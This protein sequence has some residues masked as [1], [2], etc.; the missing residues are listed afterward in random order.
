MSIRRSS[1]FCVAHLQVYE[2]VADNRGWPNIGGLLYYTK[3]FYIPTA[4]IAHSVVHCEKLL[5][6]SYTQCTTAETLPSSEFVLRTRVGVVLCQ[7]ICYTDDFRT[8]SMNCTSEY[9]CL[10]HSTVRNCASSVRRERN[11]SITMVE[12]SYFRRC[13]HIFCNVFGVHCTRLIIAL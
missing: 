10:R 13:L 1:L 9:Y 2:R 11:G 6:G 12:L 3:P 4:G 8:Q 7:I 5:S